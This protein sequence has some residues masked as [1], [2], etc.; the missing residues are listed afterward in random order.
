M[1][2][3]RLIILYLIMIT[4]LNGCGN[5][6]EQMPWLNG[7]LYHPS[8]TGWELVRSLAQEELDL[9]FDSIK[10]DSKTEA[11]DTNDFQFRVVLQTS[12]Y[13]D[14]FIVSYDLLMEE[15]TLTSYTDTYDLS[16][17]SLKAFL[18]SEEELVTHPYFQLPEASLL[19]GDDHLPL[20][21]SGAWDIFLDASSPIQIDQTSQSNYI[22][23]IPDSSPDLTIRFSQPYPDEVDLAIA[24]LDGGSY[25]TRLMPDRPGQF[26]LPMPDVA[27]TYTYTIHANF[28]PKDMGLKQGGQ[29]S[30]AIQMI[31]PSEP[32][33]V[34][35]AAEFEP[36][37]AIG[38]LISHAG[39]LEYEVTSSLYDNTV[40][41]FFKDET[42]E[43]L[44]GL[45]PLDSRVTPGDYQVTIT[46]HGTLVASLPYS[47]IPKEFD[48]QMLSV[49]SQTASLKSDENAKKDAEKFGDAKSFSVPDKL[50][51]GPFIWPVEGRISTEYAMIRYV[52]GG[53]ESSRHSGLD[54]AAPTGTPIKAVADGIVTFASDLIISGNV[55]CLD[56]GMGLFTSY[57]H[58][59]EIYVLDGQVV[60]AGDII[61]EVG[62]TG[63]STGPHLHFTVW[64]NGVY[65]NPNTFFKLDPL[66]VFYP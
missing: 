48:S 42:R 59:N 24:S 37:D 51:R 3:L 60:K 9:L 34:L 26:I 45:I 23:Q 28:L 13:S 20:S 1:I 39:D 41:L 43:D 4:V 53:K 18:M 22:W 49:S 44:V 31:K 33:Y 65:L 46:H 56:H 2:K 5:K 21:T 52:N 29:L 64:K 15:A 27:D 8:P 54:I 61:G 58:M 30:Y 12:E 6:P 7:Y 63:Y 62:S 32:E 66:G 19:V 35:S 11:L 14:A 36:G 38:V 57:V 55:V 25:R 40:G 50:W 16:Y 10:T 17:S 47:V